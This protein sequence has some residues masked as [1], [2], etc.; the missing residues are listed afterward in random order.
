MS[1]Q[2]PTAAELRDNRGLKGLARSANVSFGSNRV[3]STIEQQCL[4]HPQE[5]TFATLL[6][7]SEECQKATLAKACQ[8]LAAAP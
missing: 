2:T 8:R 7:T 6:S 5:Q 4:L 3:A 1:A